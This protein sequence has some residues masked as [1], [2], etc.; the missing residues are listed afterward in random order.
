MFYKLQLE[1]LELSVGIAFA[2]TISYPIWQKNAL[3]SSVCL[4]GSSLQINLPYFVIRSLHV[5]ELVKLIVFPISH[6]RIL[7]VQVI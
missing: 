6:C 4:N 5:T 7:P 1:H 2:L 3:K